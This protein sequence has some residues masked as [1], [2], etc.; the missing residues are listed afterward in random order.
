V[1]E[2]R[3]FVRKEQDSKFRR[4]QPWGVPIANKSTVSSNI[5]DNDKAQKALQKKAVNRLNDP[6]KVTLD[7]KK[8]NQLLEVKN[9]IEKNHTSI[10]D[11]RNQNPFEITQKTKKKILDQIKKQQP[12]D[13][14]CFEFMISDVNFQKEVFNSRDLKDNQLF[15]DFLRK[16]IDSMLAVGKKNETENDSK[17]PFDPDKVLISRKKKRPEVN[18]HPGVFKFKNGT[19]EIPKDIW[20][21]VYSGGLPSLG[22]RSR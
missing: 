11:A 1:K 15:I 9:A 12:I 6:N 4:C 17:K 7:K 20:V 5:L 10:P 19:L 22:R 8:Q 18:L 13:L 2:R 16:N 21:K 14:I 3:Q